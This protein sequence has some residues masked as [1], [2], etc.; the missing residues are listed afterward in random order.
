MVYS[1]SVD[2][3]PDLQAKVFH[4]M[5]SDFYSERSGDRSI[6]LH[7]GSEKAQP[8]S[9]KL[10]HSSNSINDLLSKLRE[11]VVQSFQLRLSLYDADIRRLDSFRG[12]P[13]L[14][15]RQLFLVKESLALMY[16]MHQLPG[17]ALIQYEELEALLSFTPNL[18]L[19]ES[20]WPWT[21]SDQSKAITAAPQ[22]EP[23]RDPS[24]SDGWIG[25]CR[26][27][28]DVLLYSMN[29][30]RTKI[31]KNKVSIWELYR[32]VFSRQ[33]FLLLQLNKPLGCCEKG[34]NFVTTMRSMIDHKLVDTSALSLLRQD[35]SS[36]RLSESSLTLKRC[37][38]D[39]WAVAA[40]VKIARACLD[41]FQQFHGDQSPS[42]LSPSNSMQSKSQNIF[43]AFAFDEESLTGLIHISELL[44]FASGKLINLLDEE[45]SYLT[46][47]HR[48]T[49][50]IGSWDKIDISNTFLQASRWSREAEHA[51]DEVDQ[52][53]ST[54][55]HAVEELLAHVSRKLRHIALDYTFGDKYKKKMK[56]SSTGIAA[57]V[58]ITDLFGSSPS[59]AP[60]SSPWMDHVQGKHHNMD[61]TPTESSSA[62]SQ[63]AST[64]TSLQ[65]NH[66][67]LV[68]LC[69]ALSE[70]DVLLGRHRYAYRE[71]VQCGDILLYCGSLPRAFDCYIN[72]LSV[73]VAKDSSKVSEASL[74][75]SRFAMIDSPVHAHFDRQAIRRKLRQ[76]MQQIDQQG[77]NKSDW[78]A[79][80][81]QLLSKL[82]I[83]ARVL[84]DQIAYPMIALE[85]IKP[86]YQSFISATIITDIWKDIPKL[87]QAMESSTN[88]EQ[89]LNLHSN[90]HS[91]FKIN[92]SFVRVESSITGCEIYSDDYPLS[93]LHIPILIAKHVIGKNLPLVLRVELVSMLAFPIEV[94]DIKLIFRPFAND[95]NILRA[96]LYP[97]TPRDPNS[98]GVSPTE[99]GTFSFANDLIAS[100]I[101]YD[102]TSSSLCI[103]PGKQ[104]FSFNIIPTSLGEYVLS[105]IK[106]MV[107]GNRISFSGNLN[108]PIITRD[109]LSDPTIPSSTYE[110]AM[111]RKE[112]LRI[113]VHDNSLQTLLT[114]SSL[115]PLGQVDIFEIRL[116]T[117]SDDVVSNFVID[118]T[119][120]S[121]QTVDVIT[122]TGSSASPP[123][124]ATIT[125]ES[126]D[127]WQVIEVGPSSTRRYK[128]PSTIYTVKG[129]TARVMAGLSL[130][131]STQYIFKIPYL[132][133][134]SDLR[135]GDV[136]LLPTVCQ[137]SGEL[138]RNNC[139]VLMSQSLQ[140]A[141]STGIA[142]DVTAWTVQLTSNRDVVDYYRQFCIKNLSNVPLD[143]IAYRVSI[144]AVNN[145]QYGDLSVMDGPIDLEYLAESSE[146]SKDR[147]KLPLSLVSLLP[148]EEF[149]A[150][151]HVVYKSKYSASTESTLKELE[152]YASTS[153]IK[154]M[155][156]RQS[157]EQAYT[158]HKDSQ[159]GESVMFLVKA[160]LVESPWVDIPRVDILV[161]GQL[162]EGLREV[163]VGIVV[164][165]QYTIQIANVCK[166]RK[167]DQHLSVL[168]SVASSSTWMAIGY[169]QQAY[170]VFVQDEVVAIV[171]NFQLIP[172]RVKVAQLPSLSIK[173]SNENV[174]NEEGISEIYP[175][176]GEEVLISYASSSIEAVV[177]EESS[178]I[179]MQT[180]F[181]VVDDSYK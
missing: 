48:A 40:S 5:S 95:L 87:S 51:N 53:V 25:S 60:A 176:I 125:F 82:F 98:S 154:F 29:A 169:T 67:G 76:V 58:T 19:H 17:E 37:Q 139:K 162:C 158:G 138:T 74:S 18:L 75:G 104:E 148:Q 84:E 175:T 38:A 10:P 177:K 113:A 12:T 129:K 91:Y 173:Y 179:S 3:A 123:P 61:L 157:L 99:Q 56:S 49:S 144:S 89:S 127:N 15:F 106:V 70:I 66:E 46:I 101:K 77:E 112:I 59:G 26:N 178:L 121:S 7:R 120:S 145:I 79:L 126:P 31:L 4:R 151:F 44:R 86:K 22:N 23:S 72:A 80:R 111:M 21:Y 146:S 180:R 52:A 64:L 128:C 109:R 14:E 55:S 122:S 107:I 63:S 170:T 160:A 45:T 68:E 13:Q 149:Y 32:Y 132:T 69:A 41:S 2:I 9:S 6:L 34:Y 78:L 11:G 57:D 110:T 103:F 134:C 30:A 108:S 140:T 174:S 85:I 153:V 35:S 163:N 27:G 116:S 88:P 96:N 166:G 118:V 124:V 93:D 1:P 164:E 143:L 142:V 152:S 105:E 133:T 73:L 150:G 155:Y 65:R 47:I 20:E 36:G 136:L 131:P 43:Q 42:D 54:P 28:D 16:Q 141:I 130:R 147:G 81:Y 24:A 8:V 135:V 94:E 117:G 90:F 33:F 159:G 92:C 71:K 102:T 165:A 114:T 115:T 100:G 172:I 119:R 161:Y 83:I 168:V 39:L 171:C 156:R 181:L 62:E 97:L 167:F 50:T 137:L